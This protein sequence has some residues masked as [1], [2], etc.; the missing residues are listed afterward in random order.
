MSLCPCPPGMNCPL[1]QIMMTALGPA[2]APTPVSAEARLIEANAVL[3][4]IGAALHGLPVSDF[5][6]SFPIVRAVIDLKASIPT[7]EELEDA[8]RRCDGRLADWVGPNPALAAR[9]RAMKG[10]G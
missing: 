6:E 5:M 9:L 3:E 7:D 1:Q 4:A 2:V 10:R 8:A